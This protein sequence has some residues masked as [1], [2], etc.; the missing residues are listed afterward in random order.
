MRPIRRVAA[1]AAAIVVSSLLAAPVAAAA[2]TVD[3]I[4]DGGHHE[5]STVYY[6][7][8]ICGPRSG[9]TTY[10]VT[11]HLRVQD[12][13]DTFNAT[14]VETGTYTTDLDDPAFDDYSSQFTGAVH[15]NVTK[16]GVAV[17]TDLWHD[18]PGSITIRTSLV[19]VVR[20]GAVQVDREVFYVSGCP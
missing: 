1:V 19:F 10:D 6:P 2:R 12:F 4:R 13:G 7:D 3:Q 17:T 5:V 18:F 9:W 16:S 8:D 15:V 14:Y 20:D 11:W